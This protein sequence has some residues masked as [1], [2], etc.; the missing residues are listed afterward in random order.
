MQDQASQWL[1]VQSDSPDWMIIWGWGAMNPT[2]VKEAT[3]VGY[4][5]DKFIGVWWSGSENDV[6]PAGEGANGYKSISFHGVG[7]DYPIYA[8]LKKY[9]FDAGKAAG[10]GD[11][12]GNVLYSRGMYAAMI[13]SE[14][15]KTAQ[16]KTGHAAVT[17]EEVRDGFENLNLTEARLTELGLPGFAQEIHATCADHGGPG[18]AM[19]LQWD[20]AFD[21]GSDT[22]TGVN[23]ADYKPPFPLTAKLNK[24]TIRLDRPQ[25]APAMPTHWD[26][27]ATN[28]GST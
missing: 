16:E 6:G 12:L 8:D 2:A 11:N 1:N 3:K 4:P 21:V 24:L 10:A 22:L 15:I 26:S 13:I 14:A 7:S 25:L 17:P 5:M 18:T 27:P 19:I 23:D 20:E 28:A 9:V